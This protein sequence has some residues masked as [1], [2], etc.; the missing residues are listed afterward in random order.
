VQDSVLLCG[1]L[2]LTGFNSKALNSSI[3][4]GVSHLK[5]DAATILILITSHGWIKNVDCPIFF[6]LKFK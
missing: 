5:P 2:I 1:K 4:S 6:V 3:K